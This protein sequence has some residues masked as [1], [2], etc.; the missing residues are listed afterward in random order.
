MNYED[1]GLITSAF[2]KQFLHNCE[3]ARHTM[4]KE[5]AEGDRIADEFRKLFP[6]V[7]DKDLGSIVIIFTRAFT[8][9]SETSVTQLSDALHTMIASYSY[10]ASNLLNEAIQLDGL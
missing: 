6:E 10:T 3:T 4:P 1:N 7:S 9:I 5:S 2:I 8:V